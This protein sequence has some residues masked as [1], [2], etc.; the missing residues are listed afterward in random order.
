[1][2]KTFLLGAIQITILLIVAGLSL[3]VLLLI[4]S[5][6]KKQRDL[7]ILLQQFASDQE[8]I[9]RV[10]SLGFTSLREELRHSTRDGR[11]EMGRNVAL[12]GENI[13][14]RLKEVG[15]L[16]R[17]SLTALSEQLGQ[18]TQLNDTR[19]LAV[20]GTVE[21]KLNALQSGNEQRLEAMRK[22]VDEKLHATLEKRLGEAFSSVSDRLERVHQGLGEMRVLTSDIG[23]LKKVLANVKVRGTWGEIQL[24]ALLEQILTPEQYAKNVAP[25]SGHTERVEFAIRLPGGEGD[26]PL[27][28]PIDSKF[29]QED[30]LRLLTAGERGDVAGVLESTKALERRLLVEAKSIREK[31]ISPPDTTDF[32]ILY[33]PT[34]GLYAETLRIDGLCERMMQEYRVVISGPTTVAALLNSLQMGFRTLAV[35]RRSSEVWSLLGQVKTEFH[36]FGDVLD[37]ARIRIEQVGKDLG[38][39]QVRSRSIEKRLKDVQELSL[40]NSNEILSL[41]N[42]YQTNDEEAE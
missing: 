33:L 19:M 10:L 40:P 34:E 35:K 12:L 6:Q 17:T 29:P 15:E 23:D 16:Q 1:M 41:D 27:W 37:K 11:E 22:L 32:A 28:L 39:A 18:L 8:R 20:Q 31:Y 3:R 7:I 24:G 13:F 38:H 30:Y 4:S 26:T 36:K 2:D 14:S 5:Q 21:E 9:E 42:K 25:I